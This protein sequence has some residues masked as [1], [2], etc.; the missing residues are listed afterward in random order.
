MMMD[1]IVRATDYNRHHS[2]FSSQDLPLRGWALESG[3][4]IKLASYAVSSILRPS[5]CLGIEGTICV[6]VPQLQINI[7][8]S[9]AILEVKFA[10]NR[11]I[12][13]SR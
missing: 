10:R 1:F 7:D 12:S 8:K 13:I 2:Q 5:N 9:L 4:N 6:E 11:S 3:R